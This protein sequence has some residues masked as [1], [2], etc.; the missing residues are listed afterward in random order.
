[1]DLSFIKGD[2]NV[3]CAALVVCELPDCEVVYEDINMVPLTVPYVPGRSY[4]DGETRRAIR[5][6]YMIQYIGVATSGST[7]QGVAK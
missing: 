2:E 4:K 3:A 5:T 1:M 6:R 7:V